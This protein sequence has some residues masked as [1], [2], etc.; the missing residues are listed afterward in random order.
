MYGSLNIDV[1]RHILYI[2]RDNTGYNSLTHKEVRVYLECMRELWS[3]LD[4]TQL[5]IENSYYFPEV[6]FY[7]YAMSCRI[8]HE[9]RAFLAKRLLDL[10]SRLN[11][12][13]QKSKRKDK[14]TLDEEPKPEEPC[15][16]EIPF[17]SREASTNNDASLTYEPEYF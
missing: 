10:L 17:E 5:T 12:N 1:F 3:Q 15:I 4:E 11:L 14:L 7:F 9:K 16:D 8:S 13:Q 2:I 6:R